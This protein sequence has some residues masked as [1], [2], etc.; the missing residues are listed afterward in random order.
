MQNWIFGG[1]EDNGVDRGRI[2]MKKR[3][4]QER[5]REDKIN[6]PIDKFYSFKRSGF[7]DERT[8]R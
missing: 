4:D 7:D 2:R 3:G 1:Q 8:Y 6:V 5:A